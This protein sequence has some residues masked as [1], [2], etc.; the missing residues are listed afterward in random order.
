MRF[1]TILAIL[2]VM[3]MVVAPV[4]M[5]GNPSPNPKDVTVTGKITKVEETA[6]TVD[7]KGGGKAIALTAATKI[8]IQKGDSKKGGARADLKVGEHV[9]VTCTED[10][11]SA[12]KI[13]IQE[14][15]K[16]K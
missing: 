14:D 5:A 9:T 10:G 12:V 11:K 13:V 3:L 8:S 16:V 15:K 6:I 1:V 7:A 4:A 2:A